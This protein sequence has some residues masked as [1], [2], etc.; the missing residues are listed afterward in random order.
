MSTLEQNTPEWEEMRKGKIGASDAPI[1]LGVSPYKT[2]FQLWEEKLGLTKKPACSAVMQRGHD[3][4]PLARKKLEEMTGQLFVPVV[5]FHASI[6]WMMCSPDSMAFDESIIAE[7]KCPGKDD[8][9]A[10]KAGIVP[11]KYIPQLQHQMEVCEMEEAIYFSFDGTEGVI[12]KILRDD[13][14]IKKMIEEERRFYE[15][16]QSFEAP[17]LTHKDYVYVD[18]PAR[19]QLAS[20]WIALN[21]SI[22]GL[23]EEEKKLRDALIS[24]CPTHSS[25]G[26]GVRI[27]KIVRKGN[28]EYTRIP[29][30]KNVNLD[31]YRKDPIESWRITE[32]Q[33]A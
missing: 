14:F 28:V 8:H 7:I 22:K 24:T 5:K 16:L 3:L 4:E 2:P 12:V 25:I 9:E 21:Q 13:K 1:I 11:E 19:I 30:L 6:E 15:C 26:G 29:E 18:D 23:Q 20:K 27:S 31:I 33:R 10:A 32:A 17:K